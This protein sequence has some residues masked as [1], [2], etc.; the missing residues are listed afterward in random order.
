MKKIIL[1]LCSWAIALMAL[2]TI[3]QPIKAES[4]SLTQEAAAPTQTNDAAKQRRMVKTKV[5]VR[6][7][8]RS[9]ESPEDLEKFFSYTINWMQ[10]LAQSSDAADQEL[11]KKLYIIVNGIVRA[12]KTKESPED[13]AVEADQEQATN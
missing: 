7:L 3:Q 9:Q 12:I 11:C 2:C 6:L 1:N 4:E 10:E 8:E 5:F 13:S